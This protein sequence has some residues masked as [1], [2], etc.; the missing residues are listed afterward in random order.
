MTQLGDLAAGAAARCCATCGAASGD[1]D[2]FLT[3]LRPF[4][5]ARHAGAS[6]RSAAPRW[7][8]GSAVEASTPEVHELRL[9]GAGR[10]RGSPSRCASSSR[11]LDDRKRAVEPDPR[12]AATDPPAPDKTHITGQRRLH[13]DGGDLELL[14]LAGALHQRAGRHR[15]R[16]A[17]RTSRSPLACTQ[18]RRPTAGNQ[19]GDMP[20]N[21]FLGPDAAGRHDAGSDATEALV[22]GGTPRGA[23]A[24]RAALRRRQ[25]TP[26]TTRA[27]R[28]PARAMR[29]ARRQLAASPVLIG[30]VDG[31]GRDRRGVHLLQREPG[32][33]VRAHLQAAT[34]ELPNA[35]KLV[36]GNEV[37]AGGFRVGVVDGITSVRRT[38]RTARS[39]RSP[40]WTSS[41]TRRSS[42]CRWTRR[43]G[44][45]PRSALG[46]K[47]V[48][49]L[50]GRRSRPSRTAPRCPLR[51][52][53]ARPRPSSRTCCRRFPPRTRAGARQALLG[54]RR[55]ARR[56]RRATSTTT[57]AAAAAVLRAPDPVMR[58]LSSPRSE[59]RN[60]VPALGAAAAEVAPVAEVQAQPVRRPRRHVRGDRPR[61]ARR[62]RR[63]SRRRRRRST[64]ATASFRVQT[65]FLAR[66][67]GRLAPPPAGTR[68]AA[69]ARCRR[70][71]ARS[72]AG[73][74]A[75]QQTPQLSDD[76]E[77]LLQALEHAVGEP[78]HAARAASD[79]RRASAG[80]EAG[81]PGGRALPDRL[82]L[83]RL[84]LQPARHA[85]VRGRARAARPSASC[86]SSRASSSPTRSAA[87]ESIA[88]GRRARQ[89]GSAERARHAGAAR[90]VPAARRS[91][92]RGG[93]D[94]QSGPDR[95][96]DPAD[97][98]RALPAE[99]RRPQ[100]HAAAA[101]TWWSTATRR[102]SP[103]APTSRASSASSNLKDVP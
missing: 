60:L 42:R 45:R 97:H 8:A 93:A 71:T 101:A 48:E 22:R 78:E 75:F 55:R 27:P 62:C 12:A 64:A 30:A 94:C 40:C 33:A 41:S 26:P 34:S 79:L 73:V 29:E 9:L 36:P 84:L 67:R 43:V 18:L 76:L 23:A 66:L 68:R 82:Q 7:S 47:Y 19:I 14:L 17:A 21:Q 87:T 70:S 100:L 37:R 90:A 88:A 50:P 20:C 85:P 53:D 10:A 89:R 96:P 103:A 58:N 25:A 1:L 69:A 51:N 35:A 31:A 6:R 91:T 32:P 102:A 59:L 83:P 74:P 98:R 72:A 2:T 44:V 46:L 13:R 52:A 81:G 39:A 92:R 11:R 56:P 99:Q 54:L 61:P 77:Q 63:R 49:L 65:P 95:L 15:A 24:G 86:R 38:G 4:A 5:R 3:R 16:A 28:L 57:I 80:L